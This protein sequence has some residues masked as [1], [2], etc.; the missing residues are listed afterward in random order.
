MTNQIRKQQ[1][2]K[3]V[4]QHLILIEIQISAQETNRPAPESSLDCIEGRSP[5]SRR[6]AAVVGEL[7]RRERTAR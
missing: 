6:N 5:K 4:K 3:R 7:L 2:L 1:L